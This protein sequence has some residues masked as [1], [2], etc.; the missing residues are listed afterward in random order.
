MT[1]GYHLLKIS[2]KLNVMS[3][4]LLTQV[5]QAKSKCLR[6]GQFHPQLNDTMLHYIRRKYESGEQYYSQ[7]EL[8][9][10]SVD[11]IVKC[12]ESTGLQLVECYA[13]WEKTPLTKASNSIVGVVS[14]L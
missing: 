9:Y 6:Q 12:L 2:K 8:K 5:L 14:A 4:G 13:D 3:I 10:R 11:E 1:L 7:I